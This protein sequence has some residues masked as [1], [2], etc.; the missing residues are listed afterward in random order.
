MKIGISSVQRLHGLKCDTW[1]A[2]K[3][4][5]I[6]IFR[7]SYFVVVTFDKFNLNNCLSPAGMHAHDAGVNG[8]ARIDFV[9]F[10]FDE[11]YAFSHASDV[12]FEFFFCFFFFHP[13]GGEFD[14]LWHKTCVKL[15]I[16]I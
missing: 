15:Q 13:G 4:S 7:C 5:V 16:P 6:F 3:P 1:I 11:I 14:V 10:L 12:L 8:T 9:F 2:L